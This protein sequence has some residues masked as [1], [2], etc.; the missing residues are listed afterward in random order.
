MDYSDAFALVGVNNLAGAKTIPT[1]IELIGDALVQ[2]NHTHTGNYDLTGNMTINGN[3]TVNGDIT[4]T[5]K[6]TVDTAQIGGIDFATHVH[7]QGVDSGGNTEQ[8][9]GGAK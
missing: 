2:G 6:L 9:T 4:C 5:G 1:V 7:S 8:D 3:L